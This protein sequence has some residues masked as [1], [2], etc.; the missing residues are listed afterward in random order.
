MASKKDLEAKIDDLENRLHRLEV[1]DPERR[2]RRVEYVLVRLV[3]IAN[4]PDVTSDVYERV[5]EIVRE[6]DAWT[7]EKTPSAALR[8]PRAHEENQLG[9]IELDQPVLQ[10]EGNIFWTPLGSTAHLNNAERK[11]ADNHNLDDLRQKETFELIGFVCKGCGKTYTSI[12][13][14]TLRQPGPGGCDGCLHK[15]RWG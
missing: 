11:I 1:S 6:M 10:N 2:L 5:G 14:R 8:I 9:K 3:T 4:D 12:Q 7:P 15:M 13:D